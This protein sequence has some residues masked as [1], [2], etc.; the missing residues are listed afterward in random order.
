MAHKKA[1]GS[2]RNGRD[3]AG[4]RLGVKRFGGQQV[5][6]GSIIVR[7]RGTKWRPGRRRRSR[8]GPHHL[9]PGRRHRRF[10]DQGRG[11]HLRFGQ[12]GPP[13][14][15]NR[16]GPARGPTPAPDRVH[17]ALHTRRRACDIGG[18]KPHAALS[19]AEMKFLDQAKVYVRS[20]DGG[21]GCVSFRRE[22]F[23]EFGGPDGGD[24][25]RGGDVV[26]RGRRRPQ[27]PHRLPL[28]AAFQGRQGRQRHGPQPRRGERRR[29]AAQGPRRHRDPRRGQR[30]RPR[31]PRPGRRSAT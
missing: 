20:G 5:L 14:P 3:S 30:H 2:S 9:R 24:G 23:I 15:R 17:A 12:A 11:P 22:K 13:P 16:P 27:H 4:Q 18:A 21:N 28:P 7:Q 25:G 8:Q 1:G 19:V 31:R 26:G 29:R 10:P 6:A